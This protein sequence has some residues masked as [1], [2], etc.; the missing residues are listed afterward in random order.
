M[1][2]DGF[3]EAENLLTEHYKRLKGRDNQS[4]ETFHAQSLLGTVYLKLN[5]LESAKPL[6][7]EAHKGLKVHFDSIPEEDRKSFAAAIDGLL[8][9]A[10]ATG[11][12]EDIKKWQG[13]KDS[14]LASGAT[15]EPNPLEEESGKKQH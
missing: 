7:E 6:L 11:N 10:Q 1:R 8:E 2:A 14:L 5:N 15:A 3:A 4:W 13:K 9:L 12:N